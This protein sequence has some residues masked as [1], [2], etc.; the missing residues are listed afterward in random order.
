M[1]CTYQIVSFWRTGSTLLNY[2]LAAYNKTKRSLEVFNERLNGG[3][4]IATSFNTLLLNKSNNIH[5]SAKIMPAHVIQLGFERELFQYLDGYP[6]LT[7]DRD[8]FDTFLSW[9]YQDVTSWEVPHIWPWTVKP[10]CDIPYRKPIDLDRAHDFI[11]KWNVHKAFLNR[12]INRSNDVTVFNYCDTTNEK[13][14]A[15]FGT[16]FIADTVPMDINYRNMFSNFE[17]ARE[18][19]YERT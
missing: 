15:F 14:S 4:P 17:E 6:I 8:P 3:I 5:I 7:I 1:N 18:I 9:Y 10:S 12:L 2:H 13:L 19:F 11:K 16:D